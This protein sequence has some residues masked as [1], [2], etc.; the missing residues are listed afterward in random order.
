MKISARNQLPG[1]VRATTLGSVVAEVMVD[2]DAGA[3]VAAITRGSV[4][5]LELKPGDKVSVLIKATEI[6]IAK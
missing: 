2:V 1:I 3:M 6:M 4:E 5:S